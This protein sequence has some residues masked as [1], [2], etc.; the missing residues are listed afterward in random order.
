[1]ISSKKASMIVN[2]ETTAM[3]VHQNHRL[4]M[5]NC[6]I[7]Y[8]EHAICE[9]FRTPLSKMQACQTGLNLPLCRGRMYWLLLYTSAWFQQCATEDPVGTRCV[10]VLNDAASTEFYNSAKS[11]A[12]GRI[13]VRKKGGAVGFFNLKNTSIVVI[14]DNV[15]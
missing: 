6:Y 11:V 5:W 7:V 9:I 12:F 10:P 3:Q 1:M 14:K 2:S 13:S 8:F 4:C 15:K